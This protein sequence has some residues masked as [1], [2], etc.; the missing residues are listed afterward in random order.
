MSNEYFMFNSSW[1]FY[2]IIMLYEWVNGHEIFIW[3]M[4]LIYEKSYDGIWEVWNSAMTAQL[5][6]S[7]PKY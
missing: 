2:R 7:T 4:V 6:S 5:E 3:E 1:I